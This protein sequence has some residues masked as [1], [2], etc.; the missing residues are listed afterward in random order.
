MRLGDIE[1]MA[2]IDSGAAVSLIGVS[3]IADLDGMDK[4]GVLDM[5]MVGPSGECIKTFGKLTVALWIGQ[6]EIKAELII[7]DIRRKMILG[8]DMLEKL[9]SVI[10]LPSKRLHTKYGIVPIN[11]LV[12]NINVSVFNNRRV[13]ILPPYSITFIPVDKPPQWKEVEIEFQPGKEYMEDTSIILPVQGERQE[14]WIP[15]INNVNEAV[16][17]EK[18]EN[19]GSFHKVGELTYL[20]LTKDESSA[21]EFNEVT[22]LKISS[23]ERKRRWKELLEVLQ[24]NKWKL[25][26]EGKTKAME[27]IKRYEDLFVLKNEPW[28]LFQDYYHT[29]DVGNA[30]PVRQKQR[31]IAL[32]NRSALKEIIM[33]YLERG[34][35]KESSSPWRS[36]ICLVNKADNTKRLAIDY[37]KV[38]ELTLPDSYPLPNINNLLTDLPPAKHFSTLDLASG[39]LQM[40]VHPND[41]HITAFAVEGG[42]YEFL[43][44]PFGLSGAP[45]SF[46][47][48]IDKIFEHI[49]PTQLRKY[50]DDLLIIGSTETNHLENFQRVL[51]ILWNKNLKIK[52]KKCNLFQNKLK[53]LG[54]TISENGVECQKE[55]VRAIVDMPQPKTQKQ[56]K[57]VLGMFSFYRRF[58]KDFSKIAKPLFNMLKK[59]SPKTIKW[60][61]EAEDAYTHLKQKLTS[62]P[63]LVNPM[64]EDTFILTTDSSDYAIGAVLAV[65]RGTI[66]PVVAYASHVLNKHQINYSTTK[67]ELY[68][69][70]YFCVYFR[71]YILGKANTVIFTDH[72]PLS[73]ITTFKTDNALLVR[74]LEILAEY[75]FTIMY[76]EGKANK[77]ADALSR[78]PLQED[79]AQD[80]LQRKDTWKKTNINSVQAGEMLKTI[81]VEQGKDTGLRYLKKIIKDNKEVIPGQ[82][83][84]QLR[85]LLQ[86]WNQGHLVLKDEVVF[87]TDKDVHRLLVP[88]HQ[89]ELLLKSVHGDQTGGHRSSEKMVSI[90]KTGFYWPTMNY[91]AQL[92]VKNCVSCGRMKKPPRLPNAPVVMGISCGFMNRISLDIV[93]KLPTSNKLPSTM[94]GSRDRIS[95]GKRVHGRY[96]DYTPSAGRKAGNMDPNH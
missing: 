80:V 88:N 89:R 61:E 81:Q 86:K 41:T 21:Q 79:E 29:I 20:D 45:S 22:K 10:D 13:V 77:V 44:M 59:D 15:I 31:P 65:D 66:Q 43:V 83:P 87:V 72:R 46:Q 24:S 70:V 48:V 90:L 57:Q 68:A 64:E 37:R 53:F 92:H 33:D 82:H 94:E 4:K 51:Q 95:A 71:Y 67:K 49:L 55:K 62:A 78:N 1:V 34:L 28:G 36:N 38:N 91:D 69:I 12:N 11:A 42:L 16:Y 50:L 30:T 23:E 75:K 63:I 9:Q 8:M 17:V 39:Y 60:T 35:I 93:G 2:L 14:I 18:G 85:T 56:V 74:W 26:D 73:Y 76:K 3:I 27:L 52:A 40:K 6:E 58:I 19:I 7:A 5:S 84:E 96:F 25:T 32:S 54:H 47:R